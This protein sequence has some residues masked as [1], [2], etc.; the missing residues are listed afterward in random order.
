MTVD[1]RG[2]F[3]NG[4]GELL[5]VERTLADDVLPDLLIQVRNEQLRKAVEHHIGQTQAHVS[6][7]E[8]VFDQLGEKPRTVRSHGLEGLRRRHEEALAGVAGLTLR[9]L[10]HTAAAAHTEHYEISIY[11]GLITLTELL[12]EPEAARV[13]V[14]NLHEEEEALEQLEKVIPEKLSEELLTA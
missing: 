5:E 13:L 7:V 12:G 10:I 14:E 9:D 3:L 1:L 11:H 8:E 2:I 4:L 6:N